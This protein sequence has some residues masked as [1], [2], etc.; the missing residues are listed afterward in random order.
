MSLAERRN[1]TPDEEPSTAEPASSPVK[2]DPTSPSCPRAP[3]EL[4][5]S[6]PTT[7]KNIFSFDHVDAPPGPS[8]DCV[9]Q[10]ADVPP[11]IPPRDDIPL[12]SHYVE[13]ESEIFHNEDMLRFHQPM[14]YGYEQQNVFGFNNFHSA[15]QHQVENNLFQRDLP[16]PNAETSQFVYPPSFS[17]TASPEERAPPVPP[18]EPLNDVSIP[19]RE[20]LHDISIPREPFHEVSIPPREPFHDVSIP[21]REPFHD[22]SIPPREPFHDVGIPPREPFHDVSIPPREPFHDVSIPP[23]E[24]F[25]EVSIPPRDAPAIPPR[26]PAPVATPPFDGYS[27]R[28]VSDPTRF[29]RSSRHPDVPPPI[30]RRQPSAQNF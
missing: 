17:H 7:S 9:A 5:L 8:G 6:S 18:R 1:S 4:V 29:V 14:F 11:P 24:P 19:P 16:Y 26:D 10:E 28:Y 12:P 2:K 30:P 21:P 15:L 22:V 27:S 20:P 13:P 23:R 3:S 25:H